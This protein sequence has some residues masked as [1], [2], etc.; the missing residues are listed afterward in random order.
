MKREIPASE[1]TKIGRQK[2]SRKNKKKIKWIEKRNE[3]VL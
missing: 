2:V 1:M 3:V